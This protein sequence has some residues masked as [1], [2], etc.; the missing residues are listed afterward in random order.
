MRRFF[1]PIARKLPLALLGSALLV[2]VGVGLAS[3]LI[4]S[5]ALRASAE[6]T[7]ATLAS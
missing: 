1:L 5:Q 6:N 2:S 3:Y 4:G 7:L